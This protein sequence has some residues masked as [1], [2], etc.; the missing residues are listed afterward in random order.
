MFLQSPLQDVGHFLVID[1]INIPNVNINIIKLETKVL[2]I[3]SF[4]L[5]QIRVGQKRNEYGIWSPEV[6]QWALLHA[7][8]WG[9]IQWGTELLSRSWLFFAL[10]HQASSSSSSANAHHQE[11]GCGPVEAAIVQIISFSQTL[12][13]F[14]FHSHFNGWKYFDSQV[15]A[16]DS[17]L[18]TCISALRRR[19][20]HFSYSPAPSF[21][22][23][24]S[25]LLLQFFKV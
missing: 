4:I 1:F 5:L 15:S 19:V 20:G 10:L 13:N 9:E 22:S 18:F 12:Y 21:W 14:C 6:K 2:S 8:H 25:Q 7:D 16:Y 3:P 24:I 11:F 17:S 23:S